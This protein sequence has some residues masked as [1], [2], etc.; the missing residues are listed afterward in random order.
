MPMSLHPSYERAVV[1]D[2][3]AYR[4]LTSGLSSTQAH[5]KARILRR[6]EREAGCFVLANP[7]VV[8]ELL[9]HVADPV[10]LGRP[11]CLAAAVALGEHARLTDG[12]DGGIGLVADSFSTVCWTL[13]N[14][15][16]LALKEMLERLGSLVTHVANT[17]R[18]SPIPQRRRIS[19]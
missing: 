1:F 5:A 15:P 3:N 11:H 6:L 18:T 19:S 12:A 4:Y 14:R 7:I 9:A 8:G 13:F 16:P 10:D 2:T 17:R